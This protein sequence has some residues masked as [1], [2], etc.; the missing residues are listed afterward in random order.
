M[1]DG[2][3]PRD[4]V[5]RVEPSEE[6]G[7]KIAAALMDVIVGAPSGQGGGSE[8]FPSLPASP[9]P[10]PSSRGSSADPLLRHPVRMVRDGDS[11]HCDF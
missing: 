10:L 7:A 4:Y 2:S 5:Q 3:H 8:L 1:L 11:D 9:P 6:G